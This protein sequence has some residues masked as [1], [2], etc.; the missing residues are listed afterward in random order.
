[1]SGYSL[2]ND[3]YLYII[4]FKATPRGGLFCS[5]W[6]GKEFKEFNEFRELRV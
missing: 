3:V 1:M 2:V 5:V 4:Y 6:W